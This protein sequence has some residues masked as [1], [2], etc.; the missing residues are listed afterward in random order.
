M[1]RYGEAEEHS[2]ESLAIAEEIGD[3]ERGVAALT[4]LGHISLG[5]D[6]PAARE[7]YAASLA[8]ARKLGDKRRLGNV[9]NG[10]A[11]LYSSEGD[12]DRAE[13]LYEEALILDRERGDSDDVA[14]DLAG[15]AVISI[16]RGLADRAREKL[17]EALVIADNVGLK[18]TG[19]IV[20]FNSIA[21]AALLRE[22]ERAA[23]FYG[24][25]EAQR[26]QMGLHPEPSD[27]SFL[28]PYLTRIREALGVSAF[29]AAEAAGR[30]L[31]Y[32]EAMSEAHSWLQG[33]RGP[34]I[35]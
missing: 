33:A 17:F 10:L 3:K 23:R 35:Q 19:L 24:W 16:Q 27:E 25:T 6:P 4:L 32:D 29:Q 31:S 26:E 22:W 30:A 18:R 5:H 20:L 15:L 28:A 8:L 12:L 9:L 14:L 34:H 13:P 1:G 7:Y 11:R 21:L 2:R